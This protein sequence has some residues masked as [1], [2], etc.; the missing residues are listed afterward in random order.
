ML[1]VVLEDYSFLGMD[2][3]IM[4]H[5]INFGSFFSWFAAKM[6]A[7]ATYIPASTSLTM[8]I[9]ILGFPVTLIRLS[10]Y[11]AMAY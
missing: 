1:M 5:Q 4:L 7:L 6:I 8:V 2:L 11:F 3:Q 9:C 10:G